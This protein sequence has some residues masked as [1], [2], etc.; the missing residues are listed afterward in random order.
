MR[1][2]G[3]RL[4]GRRITC[5]P[6]VIRPAMDRMRESVFSILG[7]L[8]G[9]SFLDLFSGSGVVALEAIS[10]GALRATL[11]ERDG[12]KRA[13]IEK[14]LE[15]APGVTTLVI[16]PVERFVARSRDSFDVAFLDPPFSYRFKADLLGRVA[17]RSL[18]A[19]RGRLVIHFP[20]TETLP[21]DAGDLRMTDERRYGGSAVRFYEWN[22]EH[23]S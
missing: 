4:S 23:G 3:G 15:L 7:P 1:I 2:T 20:A 11:V 9:L 14:N 10:R 18:L 19:P 17:R 6:G 5:P 22:P 13:I 16:A 21:D 12:H 8:D